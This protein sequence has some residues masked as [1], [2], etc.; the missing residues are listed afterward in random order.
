MRV[1]YI[2]IGLLLM[3][4]GAAVG[5]WFAWQNR[6]L[7]ETMAQ[8]SDHAEE[9]K[10][11][12]AIRRNL[13]RICDRRGAELNRIRGT[14]GR[15]ESE[16]HELESQ[17]SQLNVQLFNESGRRILAEKDEGVRRIKLDLADKQLADAEQKLRERRETESQLRAIIAE[18][19]AEIERLRAIRSRRP[20][21]KPDPLESGQIT[22][23]EL[24]KQA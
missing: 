15:Y 1:V 2:L 19:D 8:V 14:I 6:M 21:R 22:V 5:V 17:I 4:A 11:E 3:L 18:Q 23:D 7:R 16:I 13:Q 9:L 20:A 24:L 10:Q 12:Q